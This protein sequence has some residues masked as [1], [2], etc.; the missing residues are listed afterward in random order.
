MPEKQPTHKLTSIDVLET[1]IVDHPAHTVEG[2]VVMKSADKG[3]I[4]GLFG[5]QSTTK[6][7]VVAED[8]TKT[9]TV[10][11]LQ[12]ALAA[13]DKELT[14]AK[15]ELEKALAAPAPVVDEKEEMLKALPPAVQAMLKE[16]DDKLAA[17]EKAAA[18]DRA[19]FE[20]AEE[21]RADEKAVVEVKDMFKSLAVDADTLGPAL[22]RMPEE[23]A[24]AVRKALRAAEEQAAQGELYKSL[25]SDA[26]P[27][28]S[29]SLSKIDA[30]TAEVQKANPGMSKA[31][32]ME[33]AVTA[34]PNLYNDYRQELVK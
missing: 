21:K 9:P 32:A 15:G 5:P 20:K 30:A 18:D 2:W 28:G 1:S 4:D 33:K 10:E 8:Q 13:K 3:H 29:G 14:E 25:G 31:E 11:E 17:I 34:D 26:A 22:R 19:K 12:K 23:A 27:E 7:T 6:G 24:E 16:R